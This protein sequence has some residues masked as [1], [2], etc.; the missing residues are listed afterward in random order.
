MKNITQ[1]IK[2]II[3]GVALS[4]GLAWAFTA[5]TSSY[6]VGCAAC[7]TDEPIDVGSS[8]QIKTGAL[9]TGPLAVYAGSSNFYGDVKIA[10]PNSPA[11]YNLYAVGNTGVGIMP[12]SSLDVLGNVK[13]AS[14]AHG[15]AAP[16]R[17]CADT[18]GLLSL[19]PSGALN[20]NNSSTI[21]GQ[22]CGS[23][24]GCPWIVPD[25]V[26]K[27]HV[28]VKGGGGGVTVARDVV[29]NP[30]QSINIIVGTY[31]DANC[32]SAN[33]STCTTGGE[34]DFGPYVQGLPNSGWVTGFVYITW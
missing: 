19:C 28:Q 26:Y 29:V 12:T 11:Q 17:I 21:S 13:A 31:K 27:V 18:H 30:S 25:G 32:S 14:L 7:N 24:P 3:L 34:S 6:T 20:L 1:T 33:Q 15:T 5:P 16:A 8:G 4:A 9:G 22:S 2:I 23:A 10:D